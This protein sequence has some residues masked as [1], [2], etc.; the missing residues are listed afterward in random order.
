[1]NLDIEYDNGARV[2]E[3]PEILSQWQ[4]DAQTYRNTAS[5]TLDLSYGDHARQKTDIFD[6]D[7]KDKKPLVVFIHGGYWRALG[8]ET[9]SHLARGLNDRGFGVVIPS[10]QLCPAVTIDDII[11]DIRLLCAWV[12]RNYQRKII[13]TG[14]SAGGHLAAAMVATNWTEFD[15]PGDL[16]PAGLGIS[17]LYDLRPL[18]ATKLNETLKLD[19]T[20]AR[21]ASPLLWPTPQQKV[22]QAWVGG[23]ESAE[24]I[25]QSDTIAACWTGAGAP[26]ASVAVP[27]KNHFTV[28]AELTDATSDMTN[29]IAKLTE[30]Q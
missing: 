22:F 29:M 14:H 12:W 19:D 24:F 25:R 5:A 16:V 6:L 4:S 17:G 28:I 18:I 27:N 11:T 15:L 8:R 13:V 30:Q 3:F 1:M 21:K 2:P 26:T 23:D 20:S 9:F 7:E 10:Y